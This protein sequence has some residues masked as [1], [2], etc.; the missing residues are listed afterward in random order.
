MEIS[1]TFKSIDCPDHLTMW[2]VD[3]YIDEVAEKHGGEGLSAGACLFGDRERD[4]Q[5]DIPKKNVKEFKK[6]VKAYLD[7]YKIRHSF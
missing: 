4:M 3:Q 2:D 5:F 7:K 6:E 1:L